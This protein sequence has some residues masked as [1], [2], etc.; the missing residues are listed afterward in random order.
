MGELRRHEH[1]DRDSGQ[2]SSVNSKFRP[3]LKPKSFL[4]APVP[5]DLSAYVAAHAG[6]P[7]AW[8]DASS[9]L[10]LPLDASKPNRPSSR[11]G[12]SK[13]RGKVS[14]E[15]PKSRGGATKHARSES[16]APS[17][18]AGRLFHSRTDPELRQK[19]PPAPTQ[20]EAQKRV[21]GVFGRKF[22]SFGA[23]HDSSMSN[24]L[25]PSGRS[26]EAAASIRTRPATATPKS[27]DSET[28]LWASARAR[29]AEAEAETKQYWQR[30]TS[31]YQDLC[32]P[33][34]HPDAGDPGL[35]THKD[36]G[37][38]PTGVSLGPHFYKTMRDWKIEKPEL[39][40][41]RKAP[42]GTNLFE[43]DMRAINDPVLCFAAPSREEKT[44]QHLDRTIRKPWSADVAVTAQLLELDEDLPP[45]RSKSAQ[46]MRR[47][48]S[49]TPGGRNPRPVTQGMPPWTLDVKRGFDPELGYTRA[50]A[51][52]D[53]ARR[54]MRTSAF[55]FRVM[56][57][58]QIRPVTQ[59]SLVGIAGGNQ[60][61][62]G[63]FFGCT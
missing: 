52:D 17:V 10:H 5:E 33:P 56:N 58:G 40:N 19:Q 48:R 15:R 27:V 28:K 20:E 51:R 7:H 45:R 2:S 55:D 23:M 26:S 59:A 35:I 61:P 25:V 57:A 13:S 53:E 60:H 29:R 31:T 39:G 21:L 50:K 42:Y 47:A 11:S 22:D 43:P 54:M 18:S 62:A 34:R 44:K 41:T 1:A 32:R 6:R 24:E 49:A 4:G 12:A 63:A 14:G 38:L 36:D 37:H 3:S 9:S 46:G 8:T 30:M 16:S